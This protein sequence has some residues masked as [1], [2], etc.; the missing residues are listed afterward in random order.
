MLRYLCGIVLALGLAGSAFGQAGATPVKTFDDT[1]NPS[2]HAVANIAGSSTTD[3]A[4]LP[5]NATNTV[6]LR[7]IIVTCTETTAGQVTV[8]IIK[9]STAD[10]AGTSATMTAVPD[11]SSY[12]AAV[13]APLSYTG[14]GPTVGTAVGDLDDAQVGCMASAT[15]APNDVYIFKPSK[16][17]LLRGTTQQVAVN[18]GGAITGGNL[19]I[20][21]EWVETTTP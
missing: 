6:L 7:R 12:S 15:A 19:T 9:R 13:S 1:V 3:N 14:T 10:T 4:V 18:M 20:T 16:P 8:K 17:I 21:F 11:D 5:G 2:Y